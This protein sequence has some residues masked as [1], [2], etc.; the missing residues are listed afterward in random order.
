MCLGLS[1]GGVDARAHVGPRAL[2]A[3]LLLAPHNLGVGELRGVRSNAAERERAYLLHARDGDVGQA[4]LGSLLKQLVVDLAAAQD[5]PL[6]VGRNLA[7]EDSAKGNGFKKK[8]K[9][10]GKKWKNKKVKGKNKTNKQTKRKGFISQNSLL[11]GLRDEGHELGA[12]AKLLQ[13]GA[14]QRVAKQAL[15]RRHH[16][17]CVVEKK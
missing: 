2:I 8:K 6:H 12:R 7:V 3:G 15:G 1:E 17:L 14:R 13:L 9:E 5:E 10:E 16:Q 4:Q 11:V